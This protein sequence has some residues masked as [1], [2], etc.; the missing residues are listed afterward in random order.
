MVKQRPPLALPPL[1]CTTFLEYILRHHQAPSILMICLTREAFIE[2]VTFS[3]QQAVHPENDVSTSQTSDD[4]RSEGDMSNCETSEEVKMCLHPLL[5]N[6]IHVVAYS[7]SIHLVFV[8][9]LPHLR[10]HLSTLACDLDQEP[11]YL[12]TN[13]SS[14]RAPF[15]AIWGLVGLHRETAEYSAQGLSSTLAAAVDAASYSK[16]RL[17]LAEPHRIGSAN[18][19]QSE[20]AL[21]AIHH[22]TWKEQVPLLSGSILFGGEE[23]IWAG[24]TIAMGR[25]FAEWCRFV[26][27][28]LD[29][30][31]EHV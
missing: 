22:D 15:L 10:A 26:K 4:A 20:D 16:R 11:A 28:N 5:S 30:N 17:I 25:V 12:S 14:S 3:L 1:L 2:E 8:P 27:A 29:T 13:S 19:F 31:L 6:T 7:H 21:E 18:D 9:T 23:R 24:K